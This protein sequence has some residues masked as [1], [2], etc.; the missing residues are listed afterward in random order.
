[1]PFAAYALVDIASLHWYIASISRSVSLIDCMF[2]HFSCLASFT[3]HTTRRKTR[4]I[5]CFSFG[6]AQELSST[7]IGFSFSLVK[8][9]PIT[10]YHALQLRTPHI[11]TRK[12]IELPDERGQYH[13]S[14]RFAREKSQ[15]QLYT[16][17]IFDSLI[18]WIRLRCHIEDIDWYRYRLLL[19]TYFHFPWLTFTLVIFKQRPHFA[20][21]FGCLNASVSKC[22]GGIGRVIYQ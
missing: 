19:F 1:M 11:L 22:I 6:E 18:L 3:K 15:R 10:S 8:M 7:I 21:I 4:D 5:S 20:S 9:K 12:H 14:L 16:C 2:Q 13:E 17:H